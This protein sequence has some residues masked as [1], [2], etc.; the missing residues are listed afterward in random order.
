MSKY[1]VVIALLTGLFSCTQYIA[2]PY[3]SVSYGA[4][5]GGSGTAVLL[6]SPDSPYLKSLRTYIPDTLI[7][8]KSELDVIMDVTKYV[9]GLWRHNGW[10][11]PQKSDPVSILEEVKTGKNFRCV[12][13]AIVTA[14]FL[15][16]LG[17]PARVVNL[18][19]YDVE[20]RKVNAGH[21]VA[22][23][24]SRTFEKWIMLDPQEGVVP[25]RRAAVEGAGIPL[26]IV[27][28]QQA[29]FAGVTDLL[30]SESYVRWIKAYLYYIETG[31]DERYENKKDPRRLMLVPLGAKNPT[32][33]QIVK[34]LT[35]M[36]YTNS[37]PDFYREPIVSKE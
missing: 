31:L 28:F 26:N 27:E 19:T 4:E 9:S 20:T 32:V 16:A 22:E 11:E 6:S 25:L 21:V 33:F 36:V 13:Y 18:R 7:A 24:Y 35:N 2:V 29:I 1:A 5:S 10:N 23:C 34:P 30:V 12:E 37:L 14:G 8:G 17:L 3:D 15:N